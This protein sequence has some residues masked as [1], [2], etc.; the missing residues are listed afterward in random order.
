MATFGEEARLL[1]EEEDNFQPKKKNNKK[2]SFE[3][4]NLQNSQF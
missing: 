2:E 1:S 4:F 3:S